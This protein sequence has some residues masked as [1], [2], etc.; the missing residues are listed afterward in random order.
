[1]VVGFVERGWPLSIAP[2]EVVAGG[3]GIR[4]GLEGHAA[5]GNVRLQVRPAG[6]L[7]PTPTSALD[8]AASE[9]EVVGDVGGPPGLDHL[10][11]HK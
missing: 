7:L 2:A 10:N 4:V 6:Y 1:M 5:G 11:P 3:G 9:R 8:E